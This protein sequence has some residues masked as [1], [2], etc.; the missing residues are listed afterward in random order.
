MPLPTLPTFAIAMENLW[1]IGP[2]LFFILHSL[3]ANALTLTAREAPLLQ[4]LYRAARMVHSLVLISTNLIK[5]IEIEF[6]KVF[7]LKRK[8]TTCHLASAN[9]NLNKCC[10][11]QVPHLFCKHFT[12][13]T[14]Y[15]LQPTLDT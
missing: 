10:L 11:I 7:M 4:L 1:R 13:N 14:L 8:P 5:Q 15:T 6:N 2:T 3:T 12:G 9:A